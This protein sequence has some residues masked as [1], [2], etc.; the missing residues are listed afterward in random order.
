MSVMLNKYE[1]NR[2]IGLDDK[3]AQ[4]VN[5]SDENEIRIVTGMQKTRHNSTEEGE[6]KVGAIKS[7]PKLAEPSSRE[8]IVLE[9]LQTARGGNSSQLENLAN[10]AENSSDSEICTKNRALETSD[11]GKD[12]IASEVSNDSSKKRKRG[13][14]GEDKEDKSRIGKKIKTE[15][16]D[17]NIKD[18]AV[19][20]LKIL[21]KG[22][23]WRKFFVINSQNLHE[24]NFSGICIC[25][26]I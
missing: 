3:R 24:M 6:V 20:R 21:Q 8:D 11:R 22:V 2:R 5:E 14:N 19:Q 9:I 16:D 10:E 17:K 18:E 12:P 4:G 1:A 7:E 25:R 13:E 26:E 23:K 15:V